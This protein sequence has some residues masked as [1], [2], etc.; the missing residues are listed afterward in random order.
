[1]VVDALMRRALRLAERGRGQTSPNPMVG[2]SVIAPDGTI[3]GDGHHERAGLPHAEVVALNEAGARARGATLVCTLEPCS[4]HGRTGPCVE[5]IVEAGVATVIAATEDPNPT[6]AGR[7][8]RYLEAHGVKVIAGA[9]GEAAERLNAPFFMAMRHRRPW[10]ILKQAASLDGHVAAAAG[11]R[12]TI[13]SDASRRLIDRW[14]AEVDALAIG[15]ETL[16]V[17]D[18]LLTVRRLYRPRPLVRVIFDRSLRMTPS[19][20]VLETLDAGPIVVLTT[21]SGMARHSDAST[22]LEKAGADLVETDGTIRGALERLCERGIQSVLLE[23]GPRLHRAAWEA[24][25]IDEARL[26]VGPDVLGP[27]GVPGASIPVTALS[28]VETHLVGA[29]VLISGYVH[30][31]R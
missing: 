20:K 29:D 5:R 26:F 27:S 11:E 19:A 10:V 13:S 23:G 8:F 25:M 15:S 24:D 31:P 1:V 16:L 30:R 7:G 18:P 9:E 17:D 2:A 21:A 12:T 3:V 4:H 14:R 6:V 28:G 22:A